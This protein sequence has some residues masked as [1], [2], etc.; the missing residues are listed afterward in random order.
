[1][2]QTAMILVR[3]YDLPFHIFNFGKP[4]IMKRICIDEDTG[5]VIHHGPSVYE[6]ENI[7]NL[8]GKKEKQEHRLVK[9][10]L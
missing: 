9:G 3:D 10:Q 1:M 8:Q 4:G 7:L 6:S 5:R 2:E